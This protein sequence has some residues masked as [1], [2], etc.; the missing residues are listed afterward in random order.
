LLVPPLVATPVQSASNV[1]QYRYDAAGNIV[2]IQRA[3]PSPLAVSGFAPVSGAAGTAVTISGAGF[4]SNATSDG[5]RFNGVAA[6]VTAATASTLTVAVPAGATT[7]KIG[8]TVAGNT[9][10]SA[11]DFVV[12]APGAPAVS[13]FTPAAGPAGTTVTVTGTHF[14]PA[15][16]ATTV[17]LN[18]SVATVSSV[19]ATQLALTVPSATGSGRIRVATSVGSAVSDADFVVPPGTVAASDIVA[20]TRLVADGPTQG[21]GIFATNSYGLLLFDGGAGDW[22]SLQFAGF[23]INPAGATITYKI[24]RPDNTLLASGTLSA[25]NLAIHVPQLPSAGTYALL[26]G[27]GNA[28]VSMDARLE[29]N[30]V[31][32]ADGTALPI[33]RTAG[34]TARALIAAVAG[35]QKALTISG[36]ATS[37]AGSNLEYTIAL[38]NGT[39]FRKGAVSGL[40]ATAMLPPYTVTGTHA[41]VFAP[42]SAVTQS[43]FN[44][45]L[46]A[47]V[48]LPADAA[49]LAVAIANPGEGA[50]L[51][52]A[53]S[54]GENLGLGITGLVLAPAT[55]AIASLS[56]YK[57]DATLFATGYCYTDGTQCSVNLTNL[58]VTGNYGII[59]QPASGATGSMQAWL[60][61]DAGGTLVAGAPSTIALARP[62]QNGRLTFAGSA[63]ALV[64]IQVRGVATSP[65]GQGLLV[66][67]NKPDGSALTSAHLTG[68]G[69]T[70]VAPPLPVTETYTLF[71][72]PESAGKGAA[73]ATMEVL[74]DPDRSLVID[75]PTL[76]STIDVAGG[77]ARFTFAGTTGQ[78]LGLG[79]SNLA[80]TAAA[81][82]SVD[83]YKPDG[84]SLTGFGC[85]GSVG[86]CS[87]NLANLPATGTYGVVVRPASGAT[88]NF[89]TTLST[90]LRGNLAIGGPAVPLSLDRPGRNARLTF[91][92]AAGQ[93]LRLTWSGVAI[94]GATGNASGYVYNPN[95]T[96]LGSVQLANAVAGGYDIAVLPATGT[97]T[98][99]ID[100]PAGA[101][102]NATLTLTA[103]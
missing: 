30:R 56:V 62:G 44:V 11:Q 75:G 86:G 95:G 41:V 98:V 14:N 60:S 90:D 96:T 7:G 43:A 79:I 84:T 21:I 31:I 103:R 102:M 45:A 4:S 97:Y 39:T 76:A 61:H 55:A 74:L 59:V 71:V 25:A 8:V 89:A 46:A 87:G 47:G 81:N 78:N 34:Q 53:G 91:T 82:A 33:A 77:S 16:G 100:P 13:G 54:A 3:N 83:I 73:T 29:S 12:T 80:L 1:V 99:F 6:T 64:A 49:A 101:T 15:A 50:R 42:T 27:T 38:P 92:G 10:V 69:Q 48:P 51:N 66:L 85:T 58:P 36:L 19:T 57:P 23:A 35:E 18:Q 52:V 22:L 9:A 40:G 17:R 67:V 26:L 37:P 72:E 70:V 65:A 93:T 24:Y 32:P 88:G 28:Q 5:V 20:T 63:G 68:A 2:S 94:L